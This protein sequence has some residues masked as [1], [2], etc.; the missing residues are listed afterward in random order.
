MA[1]DDIINYGTVTSYQQKKKR[2]FIIRWSFEVPYKNSSTTWM[3]GR[4]AG[5][6]GA[7]YKV[8]QDSNNNNKYDGTRGDTYVGY[9]SASGPE[10]TQFSSLFKGVSGE[11]YGYNDFTAD[12]V[13]GGLPAGNLNW[14]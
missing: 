5:T 9:G 14:F 10:Y 6:S 7:K 8:Y 4:R 2:D 12:I 13:V 11:I 1:R 3:V